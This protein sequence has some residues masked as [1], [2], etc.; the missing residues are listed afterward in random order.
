MLSQNNERKIPVWVRNAPLHNA[1]C[2]LLCG[3]IC[4]NPF[5]T[6]YIGDEMDAGIVL[7]AD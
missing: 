4:F 5:N 7:D 3:R 2:Y 6:R 1:V